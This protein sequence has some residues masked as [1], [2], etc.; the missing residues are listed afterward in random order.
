MYKG[1]L[2]YDRYLNTTLFILYPY[3][4]EIGTES[5]DI[6]VLLLERLHQFQEKNRTLCCTPVVKLIRSR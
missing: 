1:R 5:L 4:C 6:A 2:K 3:K